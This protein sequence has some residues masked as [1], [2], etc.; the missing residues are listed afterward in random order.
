MGIKY[1]LR[2]SKGWYQEEQFAY[3]LVL[4]FLHA[5]HLSI[6]YLGEFLAPLLLILSLNKQSFYKVHE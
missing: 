2:Q 4:S 5:D 6:E 1:M 3:Y